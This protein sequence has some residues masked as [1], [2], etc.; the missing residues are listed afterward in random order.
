MLCDALRTQ[1]CAVPSTVVERQMHQEA[2][3]RQ[4]PDPA[5]VAA[6]ERKLR[7]EKLNK[8]Q[9]QALRTQLEQVPLVSVVTLE[10]KV[11]EVQQ[12][13]EVGPYFTMSE[14]A[15][16]LDYLCSSVLRH[17]RL[18]VALLTGPQ[19]LAAAVHTALVVDAPP[20]VVPPLVEFL[21]EDTYNAQ[22]GRTA[23]W[24]E[25]EAGLAGVY[26]AYCQGLE[27]LRAA[28]EEDSARRRA[29]REAAAAENR[30]NVLSRDEFGRVEH[31]F[32]LRLN[33][34]LNQTVGHLAAVA[35]GAATPPEPTPP[36]T[37]HGK[38]PKKKPGAAKVPPPV[39]ELPAPESIPMRPDA[40]FALDE[41]E[42]RVETVQRVADEQRDARHSRKGRH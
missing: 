7:E 36:P 19:P 38:A 5:A 17:W 33:K 10:N 14:G 6:L 29:A 41:V 35:E 16:V 34:A 18:W 26:A 2:V 25:A 39:T 28:H 1:T 4:V 13:I 20:L 37:T 40:A 3:T 11:E 15:V 23:L 27:R 9:Q 21:P 30:A 32:V 42:A 24:H 12:H 8:K 22:I 31:A